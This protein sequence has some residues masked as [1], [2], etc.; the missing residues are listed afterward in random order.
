MHKCTRTLLAVC[1]Y[2]RTVTSLCRLNS[3]LAISPTLACCMA[4]SQLTSAMNNMASLLCQNE[5]LVILLYMMSCVCLSFC[6]WFGHDT[7]MAAE[8]ATV[9]GAEQQ[10]L[11]WSKFG[12]N[13]AAEVHQWSWPWRWTWHAPA[14][15]LFLLQGEIFHHLL[16]NKHDMHKHTVSQWH[17]QQCYTRCTSALLQTL[18]SCGSQHI[19]HSRLICRKCR[20][21]GF[22]STAGCKCKLD[23]RKN[24]KAGILQC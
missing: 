24:K 10:G 16:T 22:W 12:W 9:F 1:C 23:K 17:L 2:L 21:V 15:W 5:K 4:W 6:C 20:A 14:V 11:L 8:V 18:T 13:Q 19:K 3:L 7:I